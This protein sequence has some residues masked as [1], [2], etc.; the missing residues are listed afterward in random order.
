MRIILNILLS[1]VFVT[2]T[3]GMSNVIKNKNP[4]DDFKGNEN[5]KKQWPDLLGKSG[6]EAEAKIKT[7]RPDLMVHTVPEVSF[8]FFILFNCCFNLNLFSRTS[9]THRM[10]WSPWISDPT[11]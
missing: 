2:L 9:M 6:V 1:V 7:D 11:G 8:A 3:A 10:L 4:I 5:L